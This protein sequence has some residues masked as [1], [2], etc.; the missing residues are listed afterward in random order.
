MPTTDV[1]LPVLNIVELIAAASVAL[2]PIRFA[3]AAVS[4]VASN[5][6]SAFAL[7]TLLSSK[8]TRSKKSFNR[9]KLSILKPTF[10]LLAARDKAS[11]LISNATEP[12]ASIF[13]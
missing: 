10:I 5:I 3:F 13:V 9:S 11:A 2:N 7:V 12:V 1:A 6:S 8:F 4:D